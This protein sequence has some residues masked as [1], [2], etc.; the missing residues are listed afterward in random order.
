[1]K[2][3]YETWRQLIADN[4]EMRENPFADPAD[5]DRE[6]KRLGEKPR[7]SRIQ[8]ELAAQIEPRYQRFLLHWRGIP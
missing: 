8:E 3:T 5:V 2:P 6:Q 7:W 4:E 1:M